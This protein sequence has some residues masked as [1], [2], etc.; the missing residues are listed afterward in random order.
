MNEPSVEPVSPQIPDEDVFDY[1][2]RIFEH[3]TSQIQNADT[4]ASLLLGVD[5]IL[6]GA[7]AALVATRI[8]SLPEHK[9]AIP[10]VI[11]VLLLGLALVFLGGSLY[12]SLIV[13]RPTT[14]RVK[15]SGLFYFSMI[16]AQP[17][18]EF[19]ER[20]ENLTH[21]QVRH[22]LLSQVHSLAGI[23]QRKYRRNAIGLNFLLASLYFWALA[24]L[25][26]VLG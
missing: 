4:K 10:D 8:S 15:D 2:W 17:R 20:F 14:P 18:E 1:G 12:F 23:A 19:I 21:R 25:L 6:I 5:A 11:S 3:L 24:Q 13:T 16:R 22:D 9:Y 26:T 7:L